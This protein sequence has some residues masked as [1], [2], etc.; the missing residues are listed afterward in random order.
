MCLRSETPFIKNVFETITAKF[1]HHSRGMRSVK[2]CFVSL[3]LYIEE[4]GLAVN[5]T[6]YAFHMGHILSLV[7]KC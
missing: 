5:V 7:T 2:M 3:T 1:F 6:R 4:C